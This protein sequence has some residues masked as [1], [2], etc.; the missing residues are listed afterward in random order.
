MTTIC[1]INQVQAGETH[2]KCSMPRRTPGR[3]VTSPFR[4]VALPECRLSKVVERTTRCLAIATARPGGPPPW[5]PWLL[6]STATRRTQ[7]VSAR[8]R[9]PFLD[10]DLRSLEGDMA[11]CPA[12]LSWPWRGKVPLTRVPVAKYRPQK[13]SRVGNQNSFRIS[14]TTIH[15]MTF[16]RM[17]KLPCFGHTSLVRETNS[18]WTEETC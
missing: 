8:A 6:P 2:N 9:K 12:P 11:P 10:V 16:I 4:V 3:E 1:S 7:R 15:K 18:N 5:L 17:T 14:G 13:G